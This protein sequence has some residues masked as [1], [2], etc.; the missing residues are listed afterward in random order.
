MRFALFLLFV[1][2]VGLLAQNKRPFREV[3]TNPRPPKTAQAVGLRFAAN[4]NKYSRADE[5]P[6]VDGRFSQ[7]ILA[8]TYKFYSRSGSVEI[9]AGY[10][11]KSLESGF[12]L[13]FVM[14]DF[15]RR[16]DE[17]NTAL[18]NWFLDLRVGPRLFSFLYPKL[19]L[20]LGTRTLRR[21]LI[22]QTDPN[23]DGAEVNRFFLDLPLGFSFDFPVT[24][25]TTGFGFYYNIG[26]TGGTQGGGF[27]D[28]TRL[29]AINFEINVAIATKTN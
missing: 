8:A 24:F 22:D 23:A 21:G 13:P 18:G 15:D 20:A 5:A 2:P 7:G 29:N 27:S 1:L 3:I 26:L 19:G 4:F 10:A 16:V 12:N 11:H 25:G 6:V 28:P 14:Q 17:Q 9:G